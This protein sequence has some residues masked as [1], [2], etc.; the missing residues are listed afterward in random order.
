MISHNMQA[1][2]IDF[3]LSFNQ[4][5]QEDDN[6]DNIDGSKMYLAPELVKK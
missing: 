5:I 3:G 2:L 6:V 4:N 1:I